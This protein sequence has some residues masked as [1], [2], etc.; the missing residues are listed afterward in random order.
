MPCRYAD[1]VLQAVQQLGLLLAGQEPDASG[2]DAEDGI[3][4][5]AFF[6]VSVAAVMG[7]SWFANKRQ[8]ARFQVSVHAGV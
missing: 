7:W 8:K 2:V 1:A 6:C 4:I 3:G 5:F